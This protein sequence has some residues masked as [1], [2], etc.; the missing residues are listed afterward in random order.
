MWVGVNP[1]SRLVRIP[2][3]F[4]V[5]AISASLVNTV[6]SITSATTL[7]SP[8]FRSAAIFVG[9]LLANWRAPA[10]F[11]RCSGHRVSRHAFW[12]GREPPERGWQSSCPRARP[13]RPEC[14]PRIESRAD[15]QPR[16]NPHWRFVE[17]L[18]YG[19]LPL[20]WLS[21]MVV[22][23]FGHMLAAWLTGGSVSVVVLHPL[24]ISWTS[25]SRNPHPQ[26]A[27]WGG[28]VLGALLPLTFMAAMHRVRLS[29]YY[30]LRFFAG[31]CLVANGLY[32]GIDSFG[33]GEDGGTLLH[34]GASQWGLL[35][36]GLL[37]FPSGLWLW[38]GL[39]PHFGLGTARGQVSQKAAI[40]S[41]ALFMAI[42]VAELSFSPAHRL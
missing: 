39:G 29:W 42:V 32:L 3:R 14:E 19:F 11:G 21:F 7:R 16:R 24:Q 31:V 40:T 4:R 38:H 6:F 8:A 17:T 10:T 15:C 20:C 30:F 41:C 2:L 1:L 9:A 23:E 12:L 18:K 36:F 34:N 35:G 33:R 37:A 25:F 22:H 27:A 5:S 26:L 28:P 13:R